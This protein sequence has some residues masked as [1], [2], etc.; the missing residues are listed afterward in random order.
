[1]KK[2]Q[3]WAVITA[4][5]VLAVGLTGCQKKASVDTSNLEKSFQSADTKAK[6]VVNTAVECIKKA[7]Y[8]GALAS[9]QNA[10][11]QLKLTPEQDVAVK[12]VIQRVQKAMADAASKAA[13]GANKAMGD[14]QKNLPK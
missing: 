3:M 6:E 11:S 14:M 2:I 8:A 4:I 5:A 13:E 9:L 1:M 10:A 12:D 7:D